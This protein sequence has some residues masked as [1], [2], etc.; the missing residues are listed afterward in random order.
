[1]FGFFKR[2][3]REKLR[4]RRLTPAERAVVFQ[5]VPYVARLGDADRQ[6]LEGLIRIFLAEKS[7]E[8]CGGLVITDEIRLTIAAQACVLLLHRESDMYP[9]LDS[10]LVYPSAYYGPIGRSDGG[11]VMEGR[12]VR[13]G[14]S[15]TRG[16]VV[17]SW[18]DV[19][20]GAADPA[21][22]DNVVLH[23]FAHQLDGESGSMD[24]TPE[25]GE[26]ASYRSWGRVLGD[27]YRELST[28][29]HAGRASDIDAYAATTPAEFFA[30]STEM[31]FEQPRL[32]KERHPALYGEL[33]DFYRQD[34][35][36]SDPT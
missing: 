13:L 31:F 33:A 24:G 20:S 28:R 27:E 30:V 18:D 4:E 10:I 35:A 23:E 5:K 34:P 36:R 25:L 8:G 26:R 6:E 21:D 11:L 7:F 14:E 1:M 32:L 19:E 9:N 17:L 29:L 16:L 15:W 3:R 2:R 22:G 12:Q